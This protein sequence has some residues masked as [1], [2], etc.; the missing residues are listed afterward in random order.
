MAAHPLL[1]FTKLM[2]ER[3]N[4]SMRVSGA[5]ILERFVASKTN[6]RYR[7]RLDL[8]LNLAAACPQVTCCRSKGCCLTLMI[9]IARLRLL[10]STLLPLVSEVKLGVGTRC[11]VPCH[12]DMYGGNLG[13][14]ETGLYS[15]EP[16][17]GVRMNKRM[18]MNH[19]GD[20]PTTC[21]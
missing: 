12:C 17:R 10:F 11:Y 16:W 13:Q 14:R 21:Y 4:L 1:L 3:N 5:S 9:L 8:L 6:H 2:S 20:H 19:V 7:S 18:S 15:V